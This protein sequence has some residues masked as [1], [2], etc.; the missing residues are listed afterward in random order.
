MKNKCSKKF[1]SNQGLRGGCVTTSESVWG[2]VVF[3]VLLGG[4][5]SLA[6]VGLFRVF[7]PR[8]RRTGDMGSRQEIPETYAPANVE[9]GQTRKTDRFSPDQFAIVLRQDNAPASRETDPAVDETNPLNLLPP[10]GELRSGPKDTEILYNALGQ[11]YGKYFRPFRVLAQRGPK[12]PRVDFYDKHDLLRYRQWLPPSVVY[13]PNGKPPWEVL[14][15]PPAMDTMLSTLIREDDPRYYRIYKEISFG[16][17]QK[18]GVRMQTFMNEMQGKYSDFPAFLI[19]FDSYGNVV[20]KKFKD[21]IGDD[22]AESAAFISANPR[23]DSARLGTAGT[24]PALQDRRAA[25][26]P[27]DVI[28]G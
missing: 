27:S 11:R 20:S 6:L 25:L 18:L 8:N 17:C 13:S 15:S 5:A 28:D 21:L 26:P 12:G 4:F 14:V 22:L 3:G 2:P 16:L 7:R 10:A 1:D 23:L 9:G 19:V 24:P